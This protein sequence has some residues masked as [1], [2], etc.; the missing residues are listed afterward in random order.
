MQPRILPMIANFTLPSFPKLETERLL[1]RQETPEDAKAVFAVFSEPAVTQF[2]DLD[3]F[4]DIEEALQLVERRTKRF[5]SGS[6]I[7]WGIVRKRDNTLIGSCGFT[8]NK[9]THSA[10]V[11]YELASSSWRQGIMTEAL[12]AI[13]Q[14]G[15]EEIGLRFVVAE[16][17]L[18]NIDSK[19]LL[20]KLGFQSQ[21]ILK[22]HGFWKGK[23]HDLEQ[24]VLTRS[25][26]DAI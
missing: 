17:M 22:Q 6:G 16:V 3:T 12:R 7:R 24:F 11:G 9:Q 8:W 18:D 20:E 26:T 15:F 1:L 14:F 25:M 21:G 13:L 23:H 2:H 5:E 10:E 19:N 4:T